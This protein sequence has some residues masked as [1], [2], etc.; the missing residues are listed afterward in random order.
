M[1][2]IFTKLGHIYSVISQ[3]C[4]FPEVL[5]PIY[6]SLCTHFF[7]STISESSCDR[8]IWNMIVFTSPVL[9]RHRAHVSEPILAVMV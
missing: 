7:I 9:K 3:N 1:N 5:K 4:I 2:S 8:L 6:S